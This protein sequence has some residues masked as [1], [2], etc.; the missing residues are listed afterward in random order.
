MHACISLQVWFLRNLIV[1]PPPY[2]PPLKLKRLYNQL[3]IGVRFAG[4][5]FNIVE[6]SAEVRRAVGNFRVYILVF[7]M[8]VT[9]TRGAS[10]RPACSIAFGSDG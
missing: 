1:S 2:S 9:S 10:T 6:C 4:L 5:S 7:T 3:D 8:D